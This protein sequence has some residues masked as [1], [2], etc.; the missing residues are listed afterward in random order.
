VTT[1]FDASRPD[2]GPESQPGVKPAAASRVYGTSPGT[3]RYLLALAALLALGPLGGVAVIVK[4]LA[5]A[6]SGVAFGGVFLA[7]LSSALFLPIIWVIWRYPRLL[8]SGAGIEVQQFGWRL[9]SRWENVTN[10]SHGGQIGL[11]T[12]EAMAGSGAARLAAFGDMTLGGAPFYVEDARRLIAERRY[13]P[14]DP[15]SHWLWHGDLGQELTRRAPWLESELALAVAEHSQQ[16]G[17]LSR[18]LVDAEGRPVALKSL[19]VPL[20]IIVLAIG[21]ASVGGRLGPV[22]EAVIAGLL[23]LVLAKSAIGNFVAA[24]GYLRRRQY[25]VGLLWAGLATVMLLTVLVIVGSQLTG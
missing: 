12:R 16:R 1:P 14:L 9:A 10:L 24:A 19:L 2:G 8:L 7:L 5:T 22:V 17:L 21:L 6:D 23:G 20:A 3:R 15:F 4:V 13:M 18:L 25:A 11:V